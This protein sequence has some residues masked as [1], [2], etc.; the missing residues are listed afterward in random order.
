VNPGESRLLSWG[1]NLYLPMPFAESARIELT[2]DPI[3]GHDTG[4]VQ[5]WYHIDY[6]LHAEPPPRDLGRFH[7]QWRRENPLTP[8]EGADPNNPRWNG[9]N[10]DGAENYVALAARGAGQLV[11]I[12]LQVDNLGGEW[13]GEGDDMIWVDADPETAWPPTYHGTGSEE[14]FGGGAGPNVAYHGPYTGFHLVEDPKYAGKSAMYRWCL[15]DPIRFERSLVWSIEHGHDN[16][17]ANDYTSVAYWYQLEPH[18]RFPTIP[19]VQARLPRFSE[20]IWQ[21][22]AALVECRRRLSEMTAG[23]YDA[24]DV[25]RMWETWVSGGCAIKEGR[26]EDAI[27][28]FD[29]VR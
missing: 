29:A 14:V 16:N 28:A 9:A 20:A 10:I 19:G 12:H 24:E 17:Y 18:A 3:P 8:K 22:D 1:A 7:A 26:L 2:Y 23:E 25:R 15:A 21:A 5:F 27:A 11:G 6:E 13:Y 4:V